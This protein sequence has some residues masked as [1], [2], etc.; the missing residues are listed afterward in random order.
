MKHIH[1]LLMAAGALSALS[2]AKETGLVPSSARKVSITASIAPGQDTKVSLTEA[3]DHKAM[4]LAWEQADILSI[5]GNEF[6]ITSIVSEHEAQ[7]EGEEPE[8]SPYTIIYPGNYADA[9]AFGARSYA[10]QA[11]SGNGSTAHLEYNAMVKNVTE[12]ANVSF[13][14]EW[15]QAHSGTLEQNGAIQLRLQLPEAVTTASAVTLIA[16]RA[17]FPVTNA[18]SST[19]SKEQT[20]TL[21][22]VALPSNHILEAYMMFSAAGVTFQSGDK[23]TVAVETPDAMFYRTLDMTAQTWAGGRQYTVQCKVLTENSFDINDADDLEEF[24]D[25]VNSGDML[26]Q[27]CHVSLTADLD[28]SGLGSWTPIGNG[29]FT[30]NNYSGNAFKGVFDGGGHVLQNFSLTGTTPADQGVFGF[31]GILANA[32]VKNL[33]FGAE[34]GDSGAFTVSMTGGTGDAGVVAGAVIAS[35]LEDITNYL[36]MTC[37]GSNTNNKRATCAMV[38][39]VYGNKTIGMSSLE[40]LV[41]YGEMTHLWGSNTTVGAGGVHGAGIVGY[42][43]GSGTA[44]LRNRI[45]NCKNYGDMTSEIGRTAGI[46][47]A[48]YAYTLI[49]GCENRGDQNNSC[50]NGRLGGITSIIQGMYS[51]MK[52][53]ENY[54]D[55]IASGSTNTQLGGLACMLSKGSS[56]TEAGYVKV[57]GG[58][59]HGRIIGDRVSNYHGTLIAN[60][61]NFASM[62]DVVAGGAYGTYNGG[63]YQYTVLTEDNYMGFIGTRSAANEA[64][65][66]NI[67]IEAWDGYPDAN[68][69]TIS[70]AAELLAFAAKV[71]AGQFAATEVAKLTAD[72]DCSGITSW[73]PI[74]NGSIS[75]WS[76]VNLTTTGKSFSGTFDGQNHAIKNLNMSFSSSGSYGVYGFFGIVDDGA[77]VKNLTFA[78]TCSMNIS[79]SYGA[80]FGMLAGLVKGATIK[81]IQNYAPITGGGTNSLGNNAAGRTMVGGIVGEVHPSNVAAALSNLHNYANIGTAETPFSRGNNS[82]NGG[83]GFHVGGIAGFSTNLNNTTPVTFTDCINEGDIYTNAGRSSGIVAACN[84][85]TKLAGCINHGDMVSFTSGTFRLGNITCIAGVGCVLDGCINY[86]NLT[87]LNCESV[88]GV[89]CLINDA[90]VQIKD[91]ASLGATILG[92]AVNTGGNQT[93]NGV[94]FGY[95]NQKNA[96]FSNCRVSGVFGTS[97]EDKV[98]LTADNYFQYVGENKAGNTTITTST[99]TFATE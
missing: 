31:F 71:N 45:L 51:E 60:F 1:L 59:N 66:T 85:Y 76:H 21:S 98:T 74:G 3:D 52:D 89:V 32:T 46:A 84:R 30:G 53:C 37:N 36:P 2:C 15:A 22:N 23:L 62:D 65:I 6:A 42:A 64:K 61:S 18:G 96:T 95:C 16:S 73:T 44:T 92:N 17:V 47:G 77:T 41:N 82:G 26:W 5:N 11:Q 55:I 83:N 48:I 90:S 8:Q 93:Y 9:E 69:T 24:R 88:A 13:T 54:G 79:A 97:Q 67:S 19:K 27:H 39:Y 63:D 7:F 40:N 20:L 33:T 28:L 50:D 25:G 94:L 56:D 87:A 70:N 10:A 68:V 43:N 86:G 81:N 72:I 49:E 35:T 91:C 38:G 12:Y 99:I 14:P 57:S 34:T 78:S 80:S 4:K 29:S 58:G 75:S